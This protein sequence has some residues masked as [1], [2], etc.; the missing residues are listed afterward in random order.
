MVNERK[1]ENIVRK[2]L[3]KN[4]YFDNANTV[5]EEQKS[6][7][8]LVDKLLT[9]ASKKGMGRGYPEFI[10]RSTEHTDFLIVI[11]CKA[12]IKKHQSPTLDKYSEYAVDGV[13]LYASFL[14]KE[15]DILAIAV[16][17]ENEA[18]LKISHYLQLKNT[19]KVHS[20][21]GKEILPLNDYYAAYVQ[22]DMKFNQ[23]YLKL[24]QYTK[25][26]NDLLHSKKIK[27]A[28]RSLLISGI[29][30]ALQNPAFKGS[31]LAH[32]KPEQLANNLLST[33]ADE[34]SN[35]NSPTDKVNNLKQAY[36]FVLTNTTITTD[37]YFF[38]ELIKGIETNVNNFMRTHQYFDTLGQ[39]YIEFLRYANSD[40]GLGIVLTPPHITELFTEIAGVN[41]DSVLLDN[42][43][44]TGGF[45]ISGMKTMIKDAKGNTTKISNIKKNQLIGIEYQDDIYAL[46]ISN[47]IIHGDGK[48]NVYLGDCFEVASQ[49]N[50]KFKPTIGFLNPPYKS[51]KSDLEELDFV[52]NNLNTLQKGGKCLA[53]I[54][55]SCAIATKGEVLERK[56]H[57]LENHTLEA[58]MSMPEDLFHNSKVGVVTCI[59][60]ITAHIPHP[61]G[62]KTWLGYWREDGF[63][64]TKAKG[65]VDLND[66][67]T[68]KK[69]DWLN[70]YINRETKDGLSLTKEL[71]A[72][73]EWCA[74]NYLVANYEKI[75]F[76]LFKKNTQKYLAYR[77]LNDLLDLQFS[78]R[79]KTKQNNGL[80][81]L[82][83]LFHV[84]NGLA[85]SQVEVKEDLEFD[86][87]IRYIRPSQSYAGS[88]A[89]Y[90]DSLQVDEKHIYP[91][92]TIYV[93]TDGQG[94]HSYTYVSSFSFV[95]NSNVSVLIPKVEM[96]LQEKIFYA[97]CVTS[98]RFK[99]SYGRK[100]KG[101]RLKEIMIP[102]SPPSFVYRDIFEEIFDSW[103]KVVK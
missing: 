47:M 52:I 95:P 35:A 78:N 11:E 36:S 39:F 66:S 28:Q 46:G 34:F 97:A 96:T 49:I 68:L 69:E 20:F 29:L 50:E 14:S 51:K 64:K 53:I 82:S 9:N 37:K 12:D 48:T 101:D 92:N 98:N 45:L 4:G 38:V 65:R 70:T 21:L 23:D 40:K 30:I 55:L 8:V 41:Q 76:E 88:I 67:W 6:D 13:L 103:K 74:E 59:F 86:T 84:Y 31:F 57:I 7:F 73:D 61:K 15:F 75:D 89:G 80:V 99:F 60:V 77:L 85:S 58:I 3:R 26:L 91:D 1:T 19:Q 81:A 17:G 27:E 42:C 16:S 24:L 62:K 90:V 79:S 22:S 43:M 56:K 63:V 5:V 93:S 83:N 18:E 32:K 33:I 94:S 10:V 25:E 54:P 44:G 2:Y 71:K 100:P 87:D 102:A 72:E